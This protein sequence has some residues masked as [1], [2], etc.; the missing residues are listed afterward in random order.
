V[1]DVNGIMLSEKKML[2]DSWKECF[3]R[4]L[5]NHGQLNKFHMEKFYINMA[6]KE[7]NKSCYL[8]L[9]HKILNF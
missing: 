3:K 1:L 5:S 2:M 6:N 8:K 7:I 9:S 4:K